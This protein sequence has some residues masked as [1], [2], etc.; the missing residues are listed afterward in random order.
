MAPTA[1]GNAPFLPAK[2]LFDDQVREGVFK[3]EFCDKNV[4]EI[5]IEKVCWIPSVLYD[6]IVAELVSP[7]A[8][9][10]SYGKQ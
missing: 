2:I 8:R 7:Q 10:V 3:V 9:L 1:P 6:R 5:D 4:K